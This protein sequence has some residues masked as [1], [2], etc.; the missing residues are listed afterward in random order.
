MSELAPEIRSLR[1]ARGAFFTPPQISNFVTNWAIRDAQDVV[2]EPSCGEAA[3]LIPAGQRLRSLGADLE[4]LPPQLMGVE[5]HDSSIKAALSLLEH[6]ELPAKIVA[7]DFFDL[8]STHRCDVVVGNPPYIRYQQ[9]NGD[10]RLKGL[11]AALAQGVRLTGL[12]SSWAAFVVHAAQFLK[13]EGRLGLVLPA[14][15]LTVNYAAPVRRFLLERFGKVRLLMFEDLVFPD[16]LEEVVL[17]LAEGVGPAPCFEV[18]QARNLGDLDQ[19]DRAIWS[20][21][22]PEQGG[23]WTPALLTAS[24][25]AT[26][27]ELYRGEGFSKLLDWGETY[28]GAV[29]GNNHYFT[30]TTS[31]ISDLG[32]RSNEL[33]RISPPGSRHLRGLKFSDGAWK[34]LA[35]AGGRCHL[36]MPREKGTSGAAQ[37][38]IACGERDGVQHAYKCR[39]RDPWWRVPI[40]AVPD[41]LL[42]YMDHDRPRLV[43]NDT[44]A[45]HLNS[46][47]GVALRRGLR[48]LGRDL[49]PLACLN[50]VTVL[51]GEMVGRS[52]GG[53]LLKLE[54]NE[55]DLLPV[56][57]EKVLREA[58]P[59]LRALRPQLS[60]ALRRSD[61][62]AAVN[63]V[64]RV[65]LRESL[66]LSAKTVSSLSEAREFLFSR[67]IARARS[68]RGQSR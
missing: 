7:A 66:G 63:L 48:D 3:F 42:T 52:Y 38:Y 15:L 32:L 12:A 21:F 53:G 16:V 46:L 55:A 57:S 24:T 19:L 41:L 8:E 51:G 65:L 60:T 20:N 50:S 37:R 39:V 36:F 34:Q 35:Q 1:K 13:P 9:F 22:V 11:R 54:P 64:D 33:L 68:L 4:S 26:Y 59:E 2:L 44:R 40:V 56:P 62:M 45:Y 5:L 28:L 67:R 58:G 23:K 29:T 6:C 49:L 43:T 25:L 47:Y 31:Q 18:F 17:L 61:I 10:A 27:Q 30:L 14:E